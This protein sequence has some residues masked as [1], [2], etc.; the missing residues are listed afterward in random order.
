[1][2]AEFRFQLFDAFDTFHDEAKMVKLCLL[3]IL[4]KVFRRL[5]NGYVVAAGRKIDVLRVGLP[6]HV[7]AQNFLIKSFRLR[8]AAYLEGDVTHAF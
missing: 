2:G 8:G 3:C 7:H 4:K 1:M 5:M 6:D